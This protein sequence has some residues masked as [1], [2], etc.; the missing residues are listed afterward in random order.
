[1]ESTALESVYMESTALESVRAVIGA[2]VG[3]LDDLSELPAVFATIPDPRRARGKRYELWFLLVCLTAAF[4]SNCDSLD[5]VGQWCALHRAELARY[6]GPRRHLTP[7][8]SLF[9]WLLPRL[10]VAA[11]E[12][13][14]ARWTQRKLAAPAD[15]ALALDGKTARGARAGEG[16][17]PHFLSLSTHATQETLCQAAVGEKT[18]EIPVAQALLRVLPIAGRVITADAL[19][20]QVETAR[21]IRERDAHY[22]LP[23]KENQPRLYE[24]CAAYFSDPTARVGRLEQSEGPRAHRVTRTLF[25]T[26]RLNRHL[27]R[28][29]RFPGIA[30]VLCL[31]TTTR[32][33]GHEKREVRFFLTSLMPPRAD[34]RT[35]LRLIRG[36]WSIE[37][38]HLIRDVTFGEDR[39]RVRTGQAPQVLAAL[40]NLAIT[41]LRR[42]EVRN[43]AAMRR[44]FA[45]RP[46]EALETLGLRPCS[47]VPWPTR[48]CA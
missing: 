8:G 12:G 15:D 44:H 48:R 20:T 21:L 40:R 41:L 42:L 37:A 3:A 10:S 27:A 11:I 38:K 45:A 35:L 23:V 14:L 18:N 9:R 7:T 28:Y 1:M 47:V 22:L 36:H 5:A 34:L 6:C 46:A 19:H 30:Q 31:L 25:A 4:L 26:T 29:S 32:R 39:S 2:Y 13:A 16:S 17:A 43:V 33:R 24:E